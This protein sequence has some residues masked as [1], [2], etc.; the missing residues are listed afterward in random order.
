MGAGRNVLTRLKPLEEKVER[1]WQID[2]LYIT[3]H[4]G[5][6]FLK[7]VFLYRHICSLNLQKAHCKMNPLVRRPQSLNSR[8]H[9]GAT[10][11]YN[12]ATCRLP[13]EL[14]RRTL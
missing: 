7:V 13:E 10:A 12:I 1:Q 3:T 4:K 11:S 8:Q 2:Q 6:V 14:A 5:M 9:W